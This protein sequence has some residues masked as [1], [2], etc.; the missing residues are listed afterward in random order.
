M[1]FTTLENTPI[2]IDLVAQSVTTGWS[3][4]GGVA[5]HEA[6]NAGSIYLNGFSIVAG[7]TYSI[8][9][10][11]TSITGSVGTLYTQVFMGTT[12]GT[13]RTAAGFYSETLL[14]AGSTPRLRFYS[15]ADCVV[16]IFDI[17]EVLSDT[18]EKQKNT[19]AYSEQYNKWTSYY[20]YNPDCGFGLFINLYT[21]KNGNM[22]LHE[23]NSSSR[24]EFYG[25][26]Y[27]TIV[28]MPFNQNVAFVSTFESMS[29]QSNMLMITTSEGV[30]TSLG[31]ISDLIAE[32][33]TKSTMTNGATTVTINQVEGIY[34]ASFMRDINSVGG[35][36]DGDVLK[37]NWL[38]VE[39]KTTAATKLKLFSVGVHSEKSAIGVRN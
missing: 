33:F 10:E 16:S 27:Q 36:V 20:T 5:V 32:D 28:N 1:S 14:C 17:Q 26:Q 22:Y 13:Q 34:S 31:Q 39:L 23:S 15:T 19:I 18:S 3:F 29:V 6:C 21:F 30:E 35:I 38:L 2:D 7:K 24:N 37:G 12:A 11:I 25:V 9:Y 8:T 4:T